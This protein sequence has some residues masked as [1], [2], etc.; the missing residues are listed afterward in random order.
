MQN[1]F[2]GG[3]YFNYYI[4]LT[5]MSHF[6]KVNERGI[7]TNTVTREFFQNILFDS[8]KIFIC[9]IYLIQGRVRDPNPIFQRLLLSIFFLVP[10]IILYLILYL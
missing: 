7:F 6:D 9:L 3:H 10:I 2:Y 4:E 1:M 5:S 8:I